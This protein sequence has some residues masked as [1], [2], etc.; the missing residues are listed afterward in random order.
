MKSWQRWALTWSLYS[1]G[2]ALTGCAAPAPP[3]DAPGLPEG[4]P[5]DV[6]CAPACSASE[7]CS[8]G[9]CVALPRTCPCPKESYCDLG[10]NACK[11]GCLDDSHC[12]EGRICSAR[13]CVA[14]CRDDS[15][16]KQPG[17]YCHLATMT[18]RAGCR[19]DSGCKLPGQ[20]CHQST[21]TC[22]MAKGTGRFVAQPPVDLG[23]EV[24][25]TASGDWNGD[26]VPDLVAWRRPYRDAAVLLG[27]GDGTFSPLHRLSISSN[28]IKLAAGDMNGDGKTD[29]VMI[30]TGSSNVLFLSNGDGTFSST[31]FGIGDG[32]DEVILGDFTGDGK[33]DV[34]TAATIGGMSLYPSSSMDPIRP[35]TGYGLKR[36]SAADFN[37]DGKLDLAFGLSSDGLDYFINDGTGMFARLG[38]PGTPFSIRDLSTGDLNKDGRPDLVALTTDAVMVGLARSGGFQALRSY[39][40]LMFAKNVALGYLNS[41]LHLDAVVRDNNGVSVMAGDGTGGLAPLST[42]AAGVPPGLYSQLA[43]E[44][45][46][47][48]EK[49]DV[50][51]ASGNSVI[52]LLN[53]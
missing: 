41:D 52:V 38:L 45:W 12:S 44:D 42:I 27:K 13:T 20:Y 23:F 6:T 29:L 36:G 51:I 43:L 28:I 21:M 33:L 2:A 31:N 1:I 53:Q 22:R 3:P 4:P 8:G 40:G 35:Y 30:T 9:N 5:P 11:A 15:G 49:M 10:E 7:V 24:Y 39:G 17:Q 32:P 34:V 46:N 37:Q 16:C 48:D 47:R 14:G 26:G 25:S 19:D 18:C 50:A